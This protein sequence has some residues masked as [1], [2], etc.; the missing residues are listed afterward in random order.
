MLTKVPTI[1]TTVALTHFLQEPISAE[2]CAFYYIF[3]IFLWLH[4]SLKTT[5]YAGALTLQRFTDR[6]NNDRRSL[7]SL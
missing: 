3:F 4:F 6:L 7:G 1:R 5:F 2:A